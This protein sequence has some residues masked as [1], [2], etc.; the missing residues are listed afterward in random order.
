MRTEPPPRVAGEDA[1]RCAVPRPAAAYSVSASITKSLFLQARQR[2]TGP[3]RAAGTRSAGVFRGSWPHALPLLRRLRSVEEVSNPFSAWFKKGWFR[4]TL[5]AR[6]WAANSGRSL[7]TPTTSG[8]DSRGC[9]CYPGL[10][11]APFS[12]LPCAVST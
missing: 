10:N 6:P 7:V 1:L 8:D 11:Q 5:W 4:V 3:S 9:E 2:A 12:I